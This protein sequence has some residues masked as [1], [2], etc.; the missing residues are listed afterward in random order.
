[1][2]VAGEHPEDPAPACQDDRS[3]PQVDGLLHVSAGV[4]DV[5]QEAERERDLALGP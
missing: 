5:S 2:E 1:V 3:L 4:R